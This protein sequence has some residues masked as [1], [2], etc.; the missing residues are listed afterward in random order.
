MFSKWENNKGVDM[1]TYVI[2]EDYSGFNDPIAYATEDGIVKLAQKVFEAKKDEVEELCLA[3][4]L[5]TNCAIKLL[6]ELGYTVQ[7]SEIEWG[8]GYIV[9]EER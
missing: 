7:V 6:N 2:Q 9:V 5:D 1:K 4:P 8:D 3:K